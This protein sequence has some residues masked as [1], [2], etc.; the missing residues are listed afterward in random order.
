MHHFVLRCKPCSHTGTLCTMASASTLSFSPHNHPE[1]EL[2]L[3]EV[4]SFAPCRTAR[5]QS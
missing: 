3:Q 5:K 1:G 2:R 4:K